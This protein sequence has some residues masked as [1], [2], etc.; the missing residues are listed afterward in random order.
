SGRSPESESRPATTWKPLR[1]W[2]PALEGLPTYSPIRFTVGRASPG[3]Y[4]NTILTFITRF[5]R[6]ILLF[7]QAIEF[8]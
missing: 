4:L 8:I 5:L 6:A 1:A 2:I 3:Y 7:K